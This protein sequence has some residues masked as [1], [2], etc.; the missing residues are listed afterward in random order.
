MRTLFGEVRPQG[1]SPVS[2]EGTNY[3]L[4]TQLSPDPAQQIALSPVRPA[5]AER[6]MPSGTVPLVV[7]VRTAPI[8]DRNGNPVPD[9]TLVRFV[10][11]DSASGQTLDTTSGVTASDESTGGGVRRSGISHRPA[12]TNRHRRQQRRRGRRSAVHDQRARPAHAHPP[13]P[14]PT[15]EALPTATLM[16]TPS[17]ARRPHRPGSPLPPHPPRRP[18][19]MSTAAVGHPPPGGSRS[20]ACSTP[21]PAGRSTCWP[22]WEGHCSGRLAGW[23]CL[24]A[25]SSGRRKPQ[26]DRAPPARSS[27]PGCGGMLVFLGYGFWGAGLGQRLAG[28]GWGAAGLAGLA[29]ALALGALLGM[30][31][32]KPQ[33]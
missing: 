13:P 14:T 10:A 32:R 27:R 2:V 15:G 29:G 24:T 30:E 19:P 23:G 7:R 18:Q 1:R 3:D 33:S 6:G 5:P 17:P 21:G 28:P 8:R 12:G 22:R 31:P 26:D 16:P 25:A 11:R 20:T 9:G 4:S